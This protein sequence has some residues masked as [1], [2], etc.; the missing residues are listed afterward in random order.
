MGKARNAIGEVVK[1]L[2][3]ALDIDIVLLN[4][5]QLFTGDE[6]NLVLEI[7][8]ESIGANILPLSSTLRT[9]AISTKK[10]LLRKQTYSDEDDEHEEADDDRASLWNLFT[11]ISKRSTMGVRV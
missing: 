8:R 1:G 2:G 6:Q 10:V 7:E 5:F 11:T 4:L 9:T 3:G